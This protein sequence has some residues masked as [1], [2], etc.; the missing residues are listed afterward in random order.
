[1]ERLPLDAVH[2]ALLVARNHKP[3]RI[4]VIGMDDVTGKAEMVQVTSWNWAPHKLVAKKVANSLP[5]W[6]QFAKNAG[7][8]ADVLLILSYGGIEKGNGDHSELPDRELVAWLEKESKALP[9]GICP[10]YV[11]DGGGLAITPAPMDFG[12]QAMSMALKWL[13]S[14]K[15]SQPPAVTSSPHFKV[16]VRESLLNSRGISMPAIYIEA[17]RVNGALFR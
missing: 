4:A 5:E 15:G 8:T 3:A 17:A 11:E 12:Q 9:V 16:G 13:E 2:E 7:E 10:T 1:V 6:Q 14:P